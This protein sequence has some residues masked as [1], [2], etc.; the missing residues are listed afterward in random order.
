VIDNPKRT[1]IVGQNRADDIQMA[2]LYVGNLPRGVTVSH[3]VHFKKWRI[4]L[5]ELITCRKETSMLLSATLAEFAK[6]G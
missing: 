1:K 5:T 3:R 6:Y 4:F 2:K